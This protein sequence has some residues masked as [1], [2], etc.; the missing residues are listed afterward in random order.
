MSVVL[1]RLSDRVEV[2]MHKVSPE[3]AVIKLH[4]RSLRTTN[5]YELFK[6]KELWS[7]IHRGELCK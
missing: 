3:H 5:Y 6:L 2:G 4:D 7:N 1:E